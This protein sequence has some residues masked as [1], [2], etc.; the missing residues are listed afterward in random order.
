M[1]S[2]GVLLQRMKHSN[3]LPLQRRKIIALI[4]IVALV[5]IYINPKYINL[6]AN[7]CQN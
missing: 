4:D 2:H 5:L 6:W 7:L 1:I 3:S